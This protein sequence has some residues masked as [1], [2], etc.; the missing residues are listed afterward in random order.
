MPFNPDTSQV[1]S[2]LLLCDFLTECHLPQ[3]IEIV[4]G[5]DSDESVE[6][7]WSQ[8]EIVNLHAMKDLAQVIARDASGNH[9]TIPLNY[10]K[11]IFECIPNRCRDKYETVEELIV[12]FPKYVRSLRDLPQ[13][14]VKVGD[15]LSL[16]ETSTNT[17]GSMELKCRIGVG[18]TRSITL[19]GDQIGLF[20]TLE[21]ANP[22][23][24][25]DIT[26]RHLLPTRVRVRA[27]TQDVNYA[28]TNK[29]VMFEGLFV[30]EEKVQEKVLIAYTLNGNNLKVVTL[31]IHMEIIV[32]KEIS[33][34]DPTL[35]S[36][37]SGLIDNEVNI[38]STITSELEDA[39]WI[40]NIEQHIEEQQT[41]DI[42]EEILPP[43]PPRSPTKPKG[44]DSNQYRALNNPE[45]DTRYAPLPKPKPQSRKPTSPETQT[46]SE[47]PF[48]PRVAKKPNA[49]KQSLEGE[50]QS[51]S[52][53]PSML[54]L[55]TINDLKERI[56]GKSPA[57]TSSKNIKS[58]VAPKTP[59]ATS[60]HNRPEVAGVNAKSVSHP[61]P[62]P[63]RKPVAKPVPP[64]PPE[65]KPNE[66][67][68]KSS[69]EQEQPSHSRHSIPPL[70]DPSGVKKCQSEESPT[71]S[72]SQNIDSHIESESPEA[73]TNC[74]RP[75]EAGVV[76]NQ[77]QERLKD[78][79]VSDVSKWLT[80]L[81]LSEYVER[82]TE[83]WIDGNML[84]ELDT[85]MMQ[86][87]GISS[88]LHRKKLTMFI[89]KGWIPKL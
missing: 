64:A 77:A 2:S 38:E 5:Y 49:I 80:K 55:E 41:D 74:N 19:S 71:T 68:L 22:T 62:R 33:K 18:K 86:D 78:M 23:T 66:I 42:Y 51:P 16:L 84:L 87:L 52:S 7:S 4:E 54:P 61:K 65:L 15:I 75:E 48:H 57:N 34:I 32:K 72:T 89:Q 58:Q 60:N 36:K 85:E 79:S 59:D 70:L 35:L 13:S 27:G 67:K 73:A 10:P 26:D 88:S 8:G 50:T 46:E 6:R 31:P 69:S 9:F 63:P 21:D 14:G 1:D 3:T 24:M 76:Q 43:V 44:S 40:F 45:G 56:S 37:I 11:K 82:F 30:I 39:S 28:N 47:K 29:R 53:H 81:G 17:A 25:R 12:D 20:E 83:E